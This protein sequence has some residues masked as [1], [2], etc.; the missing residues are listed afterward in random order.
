M[1]TQDLYSIITPIK[2]NTIS[3]LNRSRKWE[4][5]YNKEH[6]VVVIS[7]T[8]K[9]GEIYNIQGLKIALPAEPAKVSKETNKWTPEEYPKAL[10]SINSIFNTLTMVPF[11]LIFLKKEI[12][13]YFIITGIITMEEMIKYNEIL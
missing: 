8:G 1:Y 3:R 13:K 11:K 9:I 2:S 12:F 7:R 6:D 10:K 5:G 4:Y